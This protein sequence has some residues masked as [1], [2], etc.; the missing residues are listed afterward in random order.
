MTTT[1]AQPSTPATRE[2]PPFD[3]LIRLVHGAWVTHIA[4]AM[5]QLGLADRLADGPRSSAELARLTSTHQQTL[6]RLLRACASLGLLQEV[7]PGRFALTAL[8]ALLRSGQP[9]L[10]DFALVHA[11]PGQLRP[12]EHLAEA[13]RTGRPTA[14]QALGVDPWTYYRQHPEEGALFARAMG[15]LSAGV[16]AEVVARY[17]ASG[18]TCIVDVGGSQG[19]L[20]AGLLEQAPQARGVLFDLPEVTRGARDAITQRGLADRVELIAGDFFEAVPS[21]GDLYLLKSV[22]HDWD[23][24][25]AQRILD[26]CSRAAVCWSSRC[27]CPKSQGPHSPTSSTWQCSWSSAA[28]SGRAR[29][30]RRSSRAPAIG[31]SE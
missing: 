9:S 24:E 20:L 18:C 4:A 30:T 10:R 21:G 29:S 13:L 22:L 5:A 31:W 25:R 12:F 3:Q 16:A 1:P 6:P 19:V 17:D 28:A 11:L 2:A 8:G 15:N 23:D 26:N 27:S 7:E 14:E